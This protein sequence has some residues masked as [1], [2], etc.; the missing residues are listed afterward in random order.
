MDTFFCDELNATL[1]EIVVDNYTP[2][3]VIQRTSGNALDS[4]TLMVDMKLV[5]PMLSSFSDSV[6]TTTTYE[7]EPADSEMNHQIISIDVDDVITPNEPDMIEPEYNDVVHRQALA[8]FLLNTY[9]QQLSDEVTPAVDDNN[10]APADPPAEIE[11]PGIVGVS[12]PKNKKMM[13]RFY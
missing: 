9:T 13:M 4:P 12:A 5:D 10:A 1:K 6:T 8:S 3:Y 7:E 2:S 11:L